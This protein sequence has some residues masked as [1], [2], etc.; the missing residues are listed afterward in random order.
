M[1]KC[2][3]IRTKYN[4]TF[5]KRRTPKTRARWRRHLMEFQAALFR[6]F[7][8]NRILWKNKLV[9]Q[10]VRFR[11]RCSGAFGKPTPEQIEATAQRTLA[12]EAARKATLE[13]HKKLPRKLRYR[14]QSWPELAPYFATEEDW[15]QALIEA[16]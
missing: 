13:V 3:R 14:V 1:P 15:I 8:A 12:C 2:A 4:V 10:F 5:V 7:E 11:V 9:D 6:E 16:C